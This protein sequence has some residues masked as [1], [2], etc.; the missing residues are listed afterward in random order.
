MASSALV[1]HEL[2]LLPELDVSTYLIEESHHSQNPVECV[3][4]YDQ[5][6]E[7]YDDVVR[8]VDYHGPELLVKV[9]LPYIEKLL[10]RKDQVT[11]LEI[12][13]GS[14]ETGRL[15][16]E[17]FKQ[18]SGGDAWAR[19]RLDGT[20]GSTGML[21]KA[22]NLKPPV[23]R[24]LYHDILLADKPS[25]VLPRAEYDIVIGVG[26]FSQGHMS[27]EYLHHFITPAKEEG[28]LIIYGLCEKWFL[29]LNMQKKLDQYYEANA[30]RLIEKHL[31]PG[32]TTY[33]QGS[34]FVHERL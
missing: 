24:E 33:G 12:G 30:W 27:P 16:M 14:G 5:W 34:F 15:L 18:R 3:K 29:Q 22:R 10:A 4:L 31:L 7:T 32:Y 9:C 28:G 17:S 2:R 6:S 21:A 26:I 8:K 13:C 11:I 20:D 23:Y 19:V 1:C 25:T